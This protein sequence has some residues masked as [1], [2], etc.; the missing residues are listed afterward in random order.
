MLQTT[1]RARA[2]T[3]EEWAAFVRTYLQDH[4]ADDL[5][6][7]DVMFMLEHVCHALTSIV[8]SLRELDRMATGQGAKYEWPWTAESRGPTGM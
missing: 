6:M 1:A 2:D 3:A 7:S 5:K 4:N 8:D